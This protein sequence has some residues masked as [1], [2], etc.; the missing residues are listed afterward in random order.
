MKP[1]VFVSILV[2]VVHTLLGGSGAV[3]KPESGTKQEA[4]AKAEA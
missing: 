2:V 4:N 3:K 1:G